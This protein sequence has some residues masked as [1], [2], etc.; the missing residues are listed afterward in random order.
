MLLSRDWTKTASSC[1]RETKNMHLK[2]HIFDVGDVII[3]RLKLLLLIL[4]LILNET[5]LSLKIRK[6]KQLIRLTLLYK[7]KKVFEHWTTIKQVQEY[8]HWQ[9]RISLQKKG[10][11][12]WPE[13]YLKSSLVFSKVDRLSSKSIILPKVKI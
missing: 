11:S 4:L 10:F 12:F 1:K 3:S 8:Q 7:D 5:L 9:H 2:A 13:Q 6:R